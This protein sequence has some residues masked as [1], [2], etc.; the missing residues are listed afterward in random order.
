VSL[1][2]LKDLEALGG[3]DFVAGLARDFITE[4]WDLLVALRAAAQASDTA[5]FQ[6]DA[7]A[8]SSAATNIGAEGIVSL[9]RDFRGLSLSERAQVQIALRDLATE[10]DQVSNCLHEACPQL[11]PVDSDAQDPSPVSWFRM[12]QI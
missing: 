12:P 3:P 10:M 4:G 5:S 1:R 9:C 11:G 8:L 6:A 7:H 2:M